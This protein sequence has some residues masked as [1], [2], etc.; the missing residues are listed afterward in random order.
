MLLSERKQPE[1]RRW[2]P[3]CGGNFCHS[4]GTLGRSLRGVGVRKGERNF[5][6]EA[7]SCFAVGS[8]R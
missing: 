6:Q 7:L 2:D 4:Q 5:P 8:T 3:I 1:G